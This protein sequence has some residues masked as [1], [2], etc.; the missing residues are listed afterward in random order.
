MLDKNF[1]GLLATFAP[2]SFMSL[3][4]GQALVPEIQHQSVVVHQWVTNAQF[5]DLF[6]ISRAAPGPSL[7]I[8][9]LI[10]WHVDGLA[11]AL[12]AAFGV[13]VPSSVLVYAVASWWLRNKEQP[14][15]QAIER[16]LQPIGLGLVLAGIVTI[17]HAAHA[18]ILDI[19]AA[20]IAC[21]LLSRTKLSNYTVM[22][23][24]AAVYL[25]IYLVF[26]AVA[27]P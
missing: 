25:L 7:L 3:G 11:G 4:G 22:G 17:L 12:A 2:M 6:A 16:G 15:R 26:P 19:S 8:V 5:T 18:G 10:G 1:F 20:L 13:F 24:V 27:A 21:Y 9:S 14:F 23:G